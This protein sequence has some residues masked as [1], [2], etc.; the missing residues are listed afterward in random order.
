[1]YDRHSNRWSHTGYQRNTI[2]K[3]YSTLMENDFRNLASN[4]KT[5]KGSKVK[6][7]CIQCDVSNTKTLKYHTILLQQTFMSTIL[8]K[9]SF[10]TEIAR[11]HQK[12]ESSFNVIMCLCKL[13]DK[14]FN[15][16]SISRYIY[17]EATK[18][19]CTTE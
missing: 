12:W 2:Q 16:E 14:E 15:L 19:G 3:C 8:A 7:F 17:Q 10:R 4:L 1:M 13:A 9:S 11:R 6:K 18:H 5:K